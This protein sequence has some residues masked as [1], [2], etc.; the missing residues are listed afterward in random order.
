GAE[1]LAGLV[2]VGRGFG[3]LGERVE[4]LVADLADDLLHRVAAAGRLS[5]RPEEGALSPGGPPELAQGLTGLHAGP[6]EL[7]GRVLLFV[8]AHLFPPP[9]FEVAAT[10][11]TKRLSPDGKALGPLQGGLVAAVDLVPVDD[12]PERLDVLGPP[13]LVLEVV[14]V[15]PHVQAED[16]RVAADQGR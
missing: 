16:G 6:G 7:V 11:S 5:V 8:G 13:V 15:L 1:A 10:P 14:G 9:S 3:V 12:V 4:A 2:G